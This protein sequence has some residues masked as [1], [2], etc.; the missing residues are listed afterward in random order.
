MDDEKEIVLELKHN[1]LS[2]SP[3][4][5]NALA[6]GGADGRIDGAEKKW[7]RDAR[8]FERLS[9]DAGHERFDINGYVW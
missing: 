7:F 1:T 6:I 9:H 5:D 2:H 3:H 8:A 4:A